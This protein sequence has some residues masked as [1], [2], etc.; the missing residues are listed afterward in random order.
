MTGRW[1]AVADR[2]PPAAQD[3]GDILYCRVEYDDPKRPTDR[4]VG[5]FDGG[6]WKDVTG[7]K[8]ATYGGTVTHWCE[9]PELP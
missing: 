3:E 5:F 4:R 6:E 7:Y 8:F 1:I 2:M 9:P